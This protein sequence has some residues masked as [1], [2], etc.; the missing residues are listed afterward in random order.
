MRSTVQSVR[1]V[2]GKRACWK[3]Q[4]RF[5][6]GKT[7]GAAIADEHATGHET[8]GQP[9]HSNTDMTNWQQAERRDHHRREAASHLEVG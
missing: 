6:K 9:T 5:L 3:S 7:M 4:E 2:Y 1:G 8:W